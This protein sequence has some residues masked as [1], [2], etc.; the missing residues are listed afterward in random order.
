MIF[1]YYSYKI[2]LDLKKK[3]KSLMYQIL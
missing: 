2:L 3:V 1:Y